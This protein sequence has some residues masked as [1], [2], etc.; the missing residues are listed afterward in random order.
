MV[1]GWVITLVLV[2]LYILLLVWLARSGR[3]ERYN[4]SLM[5][6]FVLMLRTGRGR[7]ALEIIATPKRL[8]NAFGDIGVVVSLLGMLAMTVLMISIVPTVLDPGSGVE[9]LAANEI[10]VIPG[11]NP[12]VPLWYGLIA[13]IVTLVVHEGGHGILSLTNKM[14]VKSLGL[15]LAVIPIGAFV[16]PDEEDLQKAPRRSRLRVYAAGPA[17][18]FLV[19]FIVLFTMMGSAAAIEPHD[20]APIWRIVDDG[21]A[22][23]AGLQPNTMLVET[24]GEVIADWNDFILKVQSKFPGD[25]M[26][27]TDREGVEYSV[28]LGNR[29][30]QYSDGDQ[31]AILDETAEGQAACNLELGQSEARTGS[32]CSESLQRKSFVG[33]RAFEQELNKGV[34]ANPFQ[35]GPHFLTLTFLPLG[36]V[37]GQPILSSMP[38]FYETPYAEE[39]FWPLINVLYWVFWVNLMVGLTNILPMLPLDGGHLFRD[40]FAGLVEKIRPG[41]AAA[42]QERLVGKVAGGL[43][44][45]IFI[46]FLLQIFGPRIAQLFA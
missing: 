10:L 30:D 16:E 38:D 37:R 25:Q 11:I 17:V 39:V 31:Q 9:P 14:R 5:L 20:G 6:G 45:V 26:N 40:S 2:N 32:E 8:W 13:L 33:V 43:S 35:S 7:R 27:F 28:T 4:L 1:S 19:G 24:D 44:L 22:E 23:L 34:L 29:W 36:E 21:P 41:M 12:F 46:A 42:K 15:L 18:N 3:M